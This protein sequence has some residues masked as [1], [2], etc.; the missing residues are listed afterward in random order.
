VD[1]LAQYAGRYSAPDTAYVLRVENGRLRLTVEQTLVPEQ[2]MSS[3]APPPGQDV[4]VS[5]D[6]HRRE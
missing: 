1:E 2:I 5:F 4:P 6:T 3:I